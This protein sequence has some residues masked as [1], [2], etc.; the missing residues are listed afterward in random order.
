MMTTKRDYKNTVKEANAMI[1]CVYPD[2]E[3]YER[4][5][6]HSKTIP[7]I[8]TNVSTYAKVL[9]LFHEDNPVPTKLSNKQLKI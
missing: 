2:R 1:E 3:E 4:N 5:S 8:H 9:I 6:Y 7:I